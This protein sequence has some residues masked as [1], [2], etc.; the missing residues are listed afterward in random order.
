MNKR[1]LSVLLVMAM[2]LCCLAA[3]G[4]NKKDDTSKVDSSTTADDGAESVDESSAAALAD[5]F[6]SITDNREKLVYFSGTPLST[7]IGNKIENAVGSDVNTPEVVLSD[8]VKLSGSF[9]VSEL[10]YA[11]EDLLSLLGGELGASLSL[12]T[13]G[14]VINMDGAIKAAGV[15]VDANVAIDENGLLITSP[16]VLNKPIYFDLGSISGLASSE[17]DFDIE[18]VC[19]LLSNVLTSVAEYVEANFTEENA[20]HFQEVIISMLPEDKV[21]SEIVKLEGEYTGN[22]VEAECVAL[23]LDIESCVSII[24]SFRSKL[25]EDA[26]FKKA[27]VGFIECYND[28][29]YAYGF[30]SGEALEKLDAENA[31]EQ[32]FEAFDELASE[33]DGKEI[34]ADDSWKIVVKRYF[35]NGVEAR[36]DFEIDDGIDSVSFSCWDFYS[37]NTNDYGFIISDGDDTI[38]DIVGGYNSDKSSLK[39]VGYVYEDV[40]EEDDFKVVEAF[41]LDFKKES[42][43]ITLDF[44]TED[45]AIVFDYDGANYTFVFT[46]DGKT[47][48]S[49][50][51]TYSVEGDTATLTGKLL[52]DNG[53]EQASFACATTVTVTDTKISVDVALDLNMNVDDSAFSVKADAD[54]VFDVACTDDIV[55]PESGNGALVIDENTDLENISYDELL[56]EAF[57]QIIS[58]F[59]FAA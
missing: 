5:K 32:L 40:Y 3:C 20:R 17:L 58:S 49:V 1:L 22:S 21:S 26:A 24:T 38:L 7:N 19:G 18:A 55:V 59:A 14:D 12:L 9:N 29:G 31:Y 57:V 42:N 11:G 15:S 2:L 44:H 13:D 10:S 37:G 35:V 54:F 48:F 6:N 50:K 53:T 41:S 28:V 27:F 23:T 33:L 43:K 36:L 16:F 39:I 30:L 51:G 52:D 56:T 25:Y 46:D 4:D 47:A 45:V 8:K 34:E